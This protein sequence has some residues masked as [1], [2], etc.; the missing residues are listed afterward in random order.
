MTIDLG[1]LSFLFYLSGSFSG[2]FYPLFLWVIVGNGLRFGVRYLLSATVIAVVFLSFAMMHS[3]FWRLYLGL[4]SGLVIGLAILPLFYVVILRELEATNKKLQEQIDVTAFAA[5]H[6][7]LTGLPNRFLF[8]DRL[9]QAIDRS[10]RNKSRFAILFIDLDK[11]KHIND[12]LGHALGDDVLQN[13][14]SRL[15]D[16]LRDSDS[17]ARLGGDEFIVLLSD[18]TSRQNAQQ[19]AQRIVKIFNVPFNLKGHKLMVTGSV[20]I[21]IFPDDAEDIDKLINCSDVAMYK[22]KNIGG[23]TFKSFSQI[24]EI[25]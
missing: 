19:A 16:V 7:S 24:T 22:A 17:V 11:F 25:E 14:A 18:L 2:T 8:M 3:D 6:D 15:R 1:A 12:T 10:K 4:S 23:N 5:T 20:G 21:S 13:I 9:V